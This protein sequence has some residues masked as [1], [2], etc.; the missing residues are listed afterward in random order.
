MTGKRYRNFVFDLY[1]TLVDIRTDEESSCVWKT[2]S[3]LYAS[4]GA[5]YSP[6]RL[7]ER[8]ASLGREAALRLQEEGEK[9][10]GKEFLAEIDLT[11]VFAGLYLEKGVPCSGERAAMTAHFFRAL[12]RRKCKA[13]PGVKETLGQLRDSGRGVY[14]LSN[15]QRDFT[16]PDLELTGLTHC[17]DGILLSSEEGCKKPSP[18]FFERLLERYGL[19]AEECLMVGNDEGADIRGAASVGMDALYLHTETSPALTGESR[20]AYR[21]MDGDWRRAAKLLRFL[22]EA[23]KE[24]EGEPGR[25]RL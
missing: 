7:K 6:A 12:S 24:P 1:G 17:F 23:G 20:A 19:R 2:M 15:A 18:V 13:Y 3:G 14:L 9:R 4:L 16:R 21:V 25:T 5:H 22:G 10:F 8:Y 11:E